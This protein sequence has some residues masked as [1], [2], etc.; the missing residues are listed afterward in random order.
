MDVRCS[1]CGTEYEFD[2]AKVKPTGVAVQCTTCGHVFKVQRDS[3][4]VPEPVLVDAKKSEDWMVRTSDGDVLRFKELTTLQK[5]I[6]EQKVSKTDMISKTG[7]NWK[8]LGD[9][10]ELA[11]FFQVVEAAN[12]ASRPPT[13]PNGLA[14]PSGAFERPPAPPAD[15]V[16]SAAAL[17]PS[18]GYARP[19]M[20]PP[21]EARRDPG[22]E[23]D[24][25]TERVRRNPTVPPQT[26]SP[27]PVAPPPT[28]S[29]PSLST[30]PEPVLTDGF[31]KADVDLDDDDP[32]LQWQRRSRNRK[33]VLA[34]VALL[35]LAPVGLYFGH[36]PTF[37]KVF[38]P[39][40][41][42]VE[43]PPPA[44]PEIAGALKSGRADELGATLVSLPEH[45]EAEP[46]R[47]RLL[48]E[49]AW[50]NVETARLAKAL[51]E[52]AP[53]IDAPLGAAYDSAQRART[54][55]DT[56]T[57]ALANAAYQAAKGGVDETDHELEG[58]TDPEAD[59]LK[60]RAR[61]VQATA[62]GTPDAALVE[63]LTKLVAV[64]AGDARAAYLLLAARGIQVEGE[65]ATKLVAD[66]DSF[67]EK[68]APAAEGEGEQAAEG[69][70]EGKGVPETQGE[71]EATDQPE[72]SY[73]ELLNKA[74]AAQERGRASASIKLFKAAAKKNP[75]AAAPHVG[76]GWAYLDIDR[77]SS[78]LSSFKVAVR[79]E[80]NSPDAQLGY[81]EALRYTGKKAEAVAAY[82][83]FLELAPASPE[84]AMA[85]RAIS[86][87]GGG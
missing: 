23:A 53:D 57:A 85:K 39:V 52:A 87:L 62:K 9:I 2:D 26:P 82:K 48:A 25:M 73:K 54:A 66:L 55:K 71:R 18:G 24:E 77:A 44:I 47:A 76:L 40:M 49:L 7:K 69:E 84:A 4:A 31:G 86:S 5:W 45:P 72:L 70:G 41:A 50:H 16:V 59:L 17:L 58:V 3:G 21:P 81:A 42:M 15:E 29:R 13:D 61:L 37:D 36:P 1:K 75:R 63:D 14:P 28:Q 19:A 27:P 11:S 30:P 33:I 64:H 78:A 34:L 51:G 68:S 74:R 80:P 83:R 46:A 35:A 10:S 22:P 67:L 32:V 56:N 79:R 20:T 43:P 65:A 8:N 12:R 60:A 38:G 6:V